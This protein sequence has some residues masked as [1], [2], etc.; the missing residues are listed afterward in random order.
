MRINARL[1]SSETGEVFAAASIEINKDEA[2]TNLIN[3]GSSNTDGRPS[4][5]SAPQQSAQKSVKV[6]VFRFEFDVCK[7][8]SDQLNCWVN[9][10]NE[11][12]TD[13]NFIVYRE[14]G[15]RAIDTSAR[16]FV[17]RAVWL[18][19]RSSEGYS[20]LN[21]EVGSTLVPGVP[22]KLVF[23]FKNVNAD[24]SSLRLFRISFTEDETAKE[25]YAD[26][27]NVSVGN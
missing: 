14:R 12:E 10:T 23:V 16:E 26:F 20:F 7:A 4:S 22:I 1:I 13:R 17:P 11:S 25:R 21:I 5:S 24:I 19:T 6:G 3:D 9:I 8:S 27:R 18:G 2:V 15:S